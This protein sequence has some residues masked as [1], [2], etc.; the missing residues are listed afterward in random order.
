MYVID[1]Y[2][3][4]VNCG[5]GPANSIHSN[6]MNS[7]GTCHRRPSHNIPL[8]SRVKLALVQAGVVVGEGVGVM[9]TVHEHVLA[10]ETR[11]W[12]VVGVELVEV[13]GGVEADA[14]TVRVVLPEIASTTE[15]AEVLAEIG[16]T[17]TPAGVDVRVVAT[18]LEDDDCDTAA[19]DVEDADV[20]ATLANVEDDT[21]AT[22]ITEEADVA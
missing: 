6:P 12:R 2:G 13:V 14:G 4:P 22:A 17:E 15:F 11:V 1:S 8:V 21:D 18:A 3:N 19:T 7:T 9:V 16:R 20:D 10:A 5:A